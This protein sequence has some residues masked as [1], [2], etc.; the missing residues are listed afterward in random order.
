MLTLLG[1][2]KVYW[3]WIEVDGMYVINLVDESQAKFPG[4]LPPS[5][6][7]SSKFSTPGLYTPREVWIQGCGSVLWSTKDLDWA[8]TCATRY[9]WLSRK[10][11][12]LP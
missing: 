8:R 2:R 11:G 10:H 7:C 12:T 5:V 9:E 1:L 6:I 4:P 3:V